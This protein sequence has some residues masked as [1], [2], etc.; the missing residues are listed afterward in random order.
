MNDLTN[1]SA[2]KTERDRVLN[3]LAERPHALDLFQTLRR[4]ECLYG[5]KPRLGSAARPADEPVRI[6]QEPSLAFAPAPV[7]SFDRS[8][9][10]PR[11]VQRIFGLLGPNGPLP[12]H[13]TEHARD[14]A[15][16]KGD[17]TFLGF[18][19]LL[20]HRLALL[21]YRA[22]AQAQPT[23]SLDRPD[24]DRFGD[25]IGALIG[26]G[27]PRLKNRD[28]LDD[29]ARLYFAGR[30]ARSAHGADGLA[31]W[32]S[33]FFGVPARIAQCMPHW[34]AIAGADRTRL[35][36]RV[37]L[38]SSRLGQGAVAGER[39]WDVQHKFRIV[40]GPVNRRTYDEFLPGGTALAR[41]AAMV[42]QYL[43]YEFAWDLQLILERREV[44]PLALGKPAA[45]RLGRTAW[46]NT[47]GRGVDADDLV[48]IVD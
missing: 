43:G 29:A 23:V 6:G 1:S 18:L 19:D 28:T 44:P 13:L 24:E 21:F 47:Y 32:V 39:I 11:L 8:G 5:D 3:A 38:D 33:G 48:L 14:R 35:C 9:A 37:P 26:T 40:I 45:G 10:P 20:T 34:M 15:L 22:W 36:G 31:A 46:L 16:H 41:L 27:A 17:W 30:L 4:L 42:R 2:P 25:Y 12:T 7:A